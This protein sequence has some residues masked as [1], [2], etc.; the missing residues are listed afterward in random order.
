MI[1]YKSDAH[2]AG[3]SGR[4]IVVPGVYAALLEQERTACA[5]IDPRTLPRFNPGSTPRTVVQTG[6]HPRGLLD[7]LAAGEPVVVP[8]W[9]IGRNTW[10]GPPIDQP[11]DRSI[12]F[13]QVG[14]DDRIALAADL[15]WDGAVGAEGD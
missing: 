15:E 5:Q 7:A 14:P 8:R 12:R 13:V 3:G 9:Y 10:S 1:T 11:R 4:G 6:S 2:P